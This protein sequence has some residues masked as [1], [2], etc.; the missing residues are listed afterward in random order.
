M[1]VIA[2]E[3]SS[4]HELLLCQFFT[5]TE[6]SQ[7]ILRGTVSHTLKAVLRGC[8]TL[9]MGFN[10]EGV[11]AWP[12]ALRGLH[13]PQIFPLLLATGANLE[14]VPGSR[15]IAGSESPEVEEDEGRETF[16]VLLGLFLT[17]LAEY[18][19][20]EKGFG[21]GSRYIIL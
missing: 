12:P 13:P 14:R 17:N 7:S 15:R 5:S 3:L 16:F 9:H 4:L 19:A 10:V 20:R 6:E 8:H 2:K 18:P 11:L 21:R 1:C